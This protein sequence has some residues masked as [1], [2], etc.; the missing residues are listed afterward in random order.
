MFILLREILKG[1]FFFPLVLDINVKK[2]VLYIYMNFD[3]LTEGCKL[4]QYLISERKKKKRRDQF[5]CDIIRQWAILQQ[6]CDSSSTH[7][8]FLVRENG[9]LQTVPHT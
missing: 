3:L 4:S 1:I 7:W 6:A 9:V 5:A 8:L 2:W